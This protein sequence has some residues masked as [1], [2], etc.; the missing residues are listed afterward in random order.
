MTRWIRIAFAATAVTLGILLPASAA[1][2]D[3]VDPN[4]GSLVWQL[5]TSD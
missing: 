3:S 1:L 5:P 4:S 2:A